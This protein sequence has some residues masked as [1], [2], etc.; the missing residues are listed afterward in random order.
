MN[1]FYKAVFVFVSCFFLSIQVQASHIMGADIT[2]TYIGTNAA[3]QQQYFIRMSFYRDC[4]NGCLVAGP[5]PTL[6]VMDSCT[7]TT[8]TYNMNNDSCPNGCEVITLC[9]GYQTTCD[10]LN[11]NPPYP[12]VEKYVDTVTITLPSNCPN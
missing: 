4:C 8:L 10:N 7:G 1:R 12:G 3:G 11:A 9:P 5:S 2:Y 6:S